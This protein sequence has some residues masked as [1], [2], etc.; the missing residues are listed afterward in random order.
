MK[1]IIKVLMFAVCYPFAGCANSAP[2][3]LSF[4]DVQNLDVSEVSD[5]E[6]RQLRISG[7][8]FH[9]SLAVERMTTQIKGSIMLVKIELVL[10]RPELSGRF[11]Y[12]VNIPSN[13]TRVFFGDLKH[14]IW[15]STR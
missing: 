12:T 4:E 6:V 2:M 11:A 5:G 9:S 14:Q 13:V 7:L 1:N 8:A 10:T 3:V 15:P